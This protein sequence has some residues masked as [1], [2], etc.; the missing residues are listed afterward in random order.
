MPQAVE[1]FLRSL[2]TSDRARAA[3]WDAV[4]TVE[5]DA[6]AEQ[7]I[8]SLP[9]SDEV[10]ATLWDARKGVDPATPEPPAAPAAPESATRR[11]L[12]NAGAMLNPVTALQGIG[13]AVRHLPDT[14]RAVIGQQGAQFTKAGEM[15]DQGRYAEMLGHGLAGALPLIGPAAAMAGEQIAE[16]DIAGG[17]GTATG[18][19]LGTVAAGPVTRAAGRAIQPV[20]RS[21]GR[22]MYQSALKPTKAVLKD[23]RTPRGSGPDAARH[24]LLDTGLREGIPVSARGAK[25]VDAL[26]DSLNAE[27]QA[28]LSAAE[29]KGLTV[30]PTYVDEQIAA[31]AADFTDQVNAQPDLAAIRTVRDNF[32]TNPKV[33]QSLLPEQQGVMPARAPQPI[34]VQTAQRMKQNTYKGLKSKYGVERGATIEAEKAG[35]RGLKQQIEQAAPEVADLNAREGALIPLE[36]AISDAMRRRGN[37]GVFGLTPIVAAGTAATSGNALPLLA[38][39]V[40]RMPGLVSRGGIWVNRAG[41]RTGRSAQRIGR[42]TVVGGRVNASLDADD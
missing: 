20:T 30:D 1:Q 5:D 39:V 27:V 16:G 2:N 15:F 4:Y 19:G 9:F 29:S 6:Q 14:A 13:Q 37:Y 33:A 25:K 31:V 11:F 35:A 3:A 28:R 36:Q 22:A 10:R 12:S 17:L 23:V 8:R 18:L 21:V 41:R 24:A 7:V 32:A 26:V 40:D 42:A 34:P 38:S